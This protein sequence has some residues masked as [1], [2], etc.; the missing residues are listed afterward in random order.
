[1]KGAV[2][3]KPS[4]F[5]HLTRHM[6]DFTCA[7]HPS[8]A[9]QLLAIN[10]LPSIVQQWTHFAT[11]TEESAVQN[12]QLAK[13]TI[14]CGLS[15]PWM[16]R[17]ANVFVSLCAISL[18]RWTCSINKQKCFEWQHFWDMD[19]MAPTVFSLCHQPEYSQIYCIISKQIC[20]MKQTLSSDHYFYFTLIQVGR[21]ENINRYIAGQ[22]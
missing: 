4:F 15:F 19:K 13:I 12:K 1:M 16:M 5:V 6:I 14:Y 7:S 2:E 3:N 9:L 8:P 21:D 22:A 10:S 11:L 17:L 18:K 20:R